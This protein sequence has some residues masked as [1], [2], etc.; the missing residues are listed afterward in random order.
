MTAGTE[1]F[2]NYLP[3][4]DVL[5]FLSFTMIFLSQETFF[6]SGSTRHGLLDIFLSF[7]EAV[8]CRRL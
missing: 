6:C 5:L 7:G 4:D 2:L 3:F 1:D 8:S